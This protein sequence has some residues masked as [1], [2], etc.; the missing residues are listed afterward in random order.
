MTNKPIVEKRLYTRLMDV[1]RRRP[2]YV[3]FLNTLIRTTLVTK[4]KLEVR[5]IGG[6]GLREA[7]RIEEWYRNHKFFF[8]FAVPRSGT[9]FLADFLN[10]VVKQD[11]V[12]HELS[13]NDYYYQ[14]LAIQSEAAATEYI[15]KY[16]L[17]EIYYRLRPY[18]FDTFGEINPF[19]R[20]HCKALL[21][22]LPEAK[23]FHLIRD[24]K[25]VLRSMMSR[26]LFAFNDPMAK[27]IRPAPQ[28]PYA[29][30][31]GSMSRFEKLCWLWQ[32]DNRFMRETIGHT[33]KFELLVSDY[34]YF[35][36]RLLEHVGLSVTHDDWAAHTPQIINKTPTYRM[37]A[38]E[39][40]D[41]A[42][43]HAFDRICGD[44]MA[45]N[46]YSV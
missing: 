36:T 38:F 16:R 14:A 30:E 43:R 23:M 13:I 19:L 34:E 40:W 20:R 8:G 42:E 10:S 1:Y 32:E 12:Q 37:P 33:V 2:I 25:N 29:E 39:E 28:D 24:G 26:E 46:G 5:S 9:T 22:V 31:W 27:L 11:I 41:P 7:G 21:Q 15:E 3:P 44:E 18:S 45:A 4:A 35:R 6:R 17:Y